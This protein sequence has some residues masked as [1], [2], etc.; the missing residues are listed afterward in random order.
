MPSGIRF[1]AR[2]MQHIA[3]FQSITDVT[4][5]DCIIDDKLNRIIF[6]V[7]EGELGAAIG[8]KGRNIRLLEKITGK[9]HEVIEYSDDPVKFIRNALKPARVREVR[10][11]KRANGKVIAVV[12]VDPKDKGIAIGRNGR[13]AERIRLLAKRYFQIENV[14]IV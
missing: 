6:I 1:T 14:S 13:N 9:R 12:S 5:K 4:V 10:L 8:R 2:E 11:T 7:G 3:L